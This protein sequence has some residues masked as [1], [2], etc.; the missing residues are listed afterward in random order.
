MILSAPGLA[1]QCLLMRER[2]CA[3]RREG[4]KDRR[5]FFSLLNG[6]NTW[7][8]IA[9]NRPFRSQSHLFTGPALQLCTLSCLLSL[10]SSFLFCFALPTHIEFCLSSPSLKSHLTPNNQGKSWQKQRRKRRK[11]DM[12]KISDPRSSSF[13]AFFPR[14]MFTVAL[15][16]C[17]TCMWF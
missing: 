16:Q 15:C 5:P 17:P 7:A 1:G 2:V 4:F 14:V 8:F 10:W 12:E 11:H 3:D 9:T 13:L 6:P